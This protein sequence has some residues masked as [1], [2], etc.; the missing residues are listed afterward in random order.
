MLLCTV[1]SLGELAVLYPVNGA[2]FTYSYRFL[3]RSWGFAMGW[4]YAISWLTVLPF[5]ITAA[6]LTI[7]F[8]RDDINIGVWITV[9]LFILCVI[10]VFGVRGYGEV[11]FVLSM[12]KIA[13][14]VGFIIF[15][16][17]VDCGGVPTDNR[18]YIGGRYWHDPGAFRNGF[19]GFCSV[20]V[21]A[22]FAF[23]GTELVGLAAAEAADPRKTIPRASKQVFWRITLFYVLNLLLVGLIVPSDSDVL[24]GSS[25]ANTKASPFVLAIQLAG[26]KALPSIFNVVITISVISVANSCTYASSRTLQALAERGMAPQIFTYIDKKGRPMP[27]IILQL[28]FGLLA[29]INE[30]KAGDEVFTWLLSLSGLAYFFAWGSICAS[31]LRFRHGWKAQGKTLDQIPW[32]SPVG[33]VG[34][35]IG[36][37]LCILCLIATFYTALYPPGGSP[38]AKAFFEQYLAAFIV[39]ACYIGWKVWTKDWSLY[40]KGHQMDVD[41]GIRQID[42]EPLP[43]KDFTGAAGPLKKIWDLMC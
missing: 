17:I 41:S 22:A 21:T 38:E 27:A 24:L 32:T 18:G 30:A 25:G 26:V 29:F 39:L 42:L 40:I 34:S 4:N 35:S 12:I 1:Q 2:F 3:D 5:E 16:I 9:F 15:G 13:A 43:P 10:Q 8:W 11:E 6:G 23:G 31:H 7:Q 14:C 20:F 33:V 36:L 37:L 19:R 28:V